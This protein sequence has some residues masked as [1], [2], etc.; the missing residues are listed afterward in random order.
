MITSILI[1]LLAV[2]NATSLLG[3]PVG[4]YEWQIDYEPKCGIFEP[5]N[6]TL[7]LSRCQEVNIVV[8]IVQKKIIIFFTGKSRDFIRNSFYIFLGE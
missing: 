4:R 1:L 7:T 8:T 6:V 5:T 3:Y 2:T